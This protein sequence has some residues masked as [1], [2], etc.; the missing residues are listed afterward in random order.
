MPANTRQHAPPRSGDRSFLAPNN[1]TP[2]PSPD[3][4]LVTCV[5]FPLVTSGITM[6]IK[7]RQ[8]NDNA[9]EMFQSLVLSFFPLSAFR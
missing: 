7:V 9:C 8:D 3:Y 1:H 2:R 4:P 6:K 5:T